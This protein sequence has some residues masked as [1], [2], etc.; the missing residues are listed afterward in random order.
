[1]N[2][3]SLLTAIIITLMLCTIGGIGGYA[4]GKHENSF[5]QKETETM[6]FARD[7]GY[8]QSCVELSYSLGMLS[9][10]DYNSYLEASDKYEKDPNSKNLE[11]LSEL[12]NRL[13]IDL[14][15]WNDMENENSV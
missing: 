4:Y 7:I 15:M 2:K 13:L 9:D 5:S 1:M 14:P 8:K 6:E 10:D 12:V 3:T 11:N